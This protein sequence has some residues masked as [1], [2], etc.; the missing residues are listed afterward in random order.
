MYHTIHNARFFEDKSNGQTMRSAITFST[1]DIVNINCIWGEDSGAVE[2]VLLTL[3][4][5]DI[6]GASEVFIFEGEAFK[7]EIEMLH[8]LSIALSDTQ[9]YFKDEQGNI[10]PFGKIIYVNAAKGGF[11]MAPGIDIALHPT[12][13][14]PQF[15]DDYTNWMDLTK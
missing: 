7:H 10:F 15:I 14:W 9:P 2:R 13:E 3:R 12:K 1:K 4:S 6:N 8:A 11:V 5:V